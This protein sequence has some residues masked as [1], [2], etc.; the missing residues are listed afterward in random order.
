MPCVEVCIIEFVLIRKGHVMRK[1]NQH[2]HA[3]RSPR[4]LRLEVL[5][6]R[7]LP[8]YTITDLIGPPFSGGGISRS[9]HGI[10]NLGQVVGTLRSHAVVWDPMT[11]VR[12]LGEGNAYVINDAGQIIWRS[13]T[14][15]GAIRH[16]WF[17][18]PDGTTTEIPFP[19]LT[20]SNTGQVVGSRS[21]SGNTHILAW[22]PMSG[23]QDLGPLGS[24]GGEGYTN[25]ITDAGGSDQVIGAQDIPNDSHDVHPFLWDSQNGI[26]DLGAIG[27]SPSDSHALAINSIG[28]VV[29]YT[30]PV[31][32]PHAFLYDGTMHDLGTAPGQTRSTA[33]ALNNVGVVVGGNFIYASGVWTDLNDLIDPGSGLRIVS[34]Y[35]VNDAGWI[36]AQA[37]DA[38]Q[39]PNIH[40]VVLRPDDGG[41]Q[42]RADSG[43]LRLR[44]SVPEATR[45]G[46]VTN[47]P[48]TNVVRERTA[49]ETVASLPGDGMRRRVTDAVFTSSHRTQAPKTGG[50]W[51]VEASA[52]NW[53]L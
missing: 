33:S 9:P 21:I 18:D 8:S 27:S 35:A 28:Q 42:G 19:A 30:G 37:W 4:S 23:E 31:G 11:G 22:D 17:T 12:D 7:C 1:P 2:R 32:Q 36:T 40:W 14:F 51:E 10:N 26:Q 3:R 52:V 24:L 53:S 39:P 46:Q 29:G 20:F 43:G 6:D 34:T 25:E 13:V 41:G 49:V 50:S 15:P 45:V 47:Q 5:E 48:R 16:D 44:A 38:A